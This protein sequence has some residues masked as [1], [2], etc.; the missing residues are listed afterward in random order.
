MKLVP[1][2]E[3]KRGDGKS[4]RLL[5]RMLDDKYALEHAAVTRKQ[6]LDRIRKVLGSS[7]AAEEQSVREAY[8]A[9]AKRRGILDGGAP[10]TDENALKAR[11]DQDGFFEWSQRMG[12][13][14]EL[15]VFELDEAMSQIAVA[16]ADVD[17]PNK[18]AHDSVDFEHLLVWWLESL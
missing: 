3:R 4:E 8:I 11:L 18:Q 2:A 10:V 14:P 13:Y 1:E 7:A 16:G 9:V 5:A 17:D 6:H 12:C 15:S